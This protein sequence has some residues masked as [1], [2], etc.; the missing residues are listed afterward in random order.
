MQWPTHSEIQQNLQ[1]Y[2]GE[3]GEKEKQNNLSA[4]KK[5]T[6]DARVEMNNLIWIACSTSWGYHAG[7]LMRVMFGSV[8]MQLWGCVLMSMAHVT[9]KGHENICGWAATWDSGWCPRAV[10]SWLCPT[11]TGCGT[12]KKRS[13]HCIAHNMEKL[14]PSLLTTCRGQRAGPGVMRAGEL[15]LFLTSCGTWKSSSC[16]FPG[17]HNSDGLG[18]NGTGKPSWGCESRRT[19]PPPCHL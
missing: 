2:V 16:T 13:C 4:I 5:Q 10:Q 8:A 1:V 19:G 12:W 7:L 11:S 6:G 9:T 14:S 17:Q 18:G 3:R 15:V